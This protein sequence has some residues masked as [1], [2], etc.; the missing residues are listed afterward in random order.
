MSMTRVRASKVATK[1][2]VSK[3]VKNLEAGAAEGGG[4]S[5]LMGAEGAVGVDVPLW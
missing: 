2:L 1:G 3:K 5:F 4:F